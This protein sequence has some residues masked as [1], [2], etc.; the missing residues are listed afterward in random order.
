M[1][2]TG[3][4]A[5]ELLG[6]TLPH[7]HLIADL[8]PRPGTVAG[9]ALAERIRPAGGADLYRAPLTMDLLGE[10][11]LGAPNRDNELL[12]D[13][14]RITDE[15]AGFARAGGGTIVDLT[16]DGLGRDPAALRRI[17]ESSGLNIVMGSGWYHPAWVEGLADRTAESLTAELVHDLTDGVDGVR[18]GIIGELA[19]LD[20]GDPAERAVLAAAARASRETGAPISIDRSP[21]PRL[22]QSVLDALADEGADLARVAVG[23]CDALTPRPE[24]LQPLL[25]RGVYVQFDALGRLPSV[26]SLADDR[27]VATAVIELGRRGYTDRILLSHDIS[28][29][30]QLLSYGGGGYGFL[31]E[32]FLPYLRGMSGADDALLEAITVQN[33]RRFLTIRTAETGRGG[34]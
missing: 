18:A 16:S 23:H 21:D 2:V 22:Q 28:R 10:V 8:T 1:T 3:P 32:Q 33:P 20:P 14:R 26:L 11:S 17:A 5:P 24:E 27:D 29:K 19:A 31:L 13:E 25:D 30:E 15:I 4:V 34:T 12:D 9:R 7:E 6:R